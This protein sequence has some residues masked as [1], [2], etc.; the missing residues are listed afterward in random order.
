MSANASIKAAPT[1]TSNGQLNDLMLEIQ[2]LKTYFYTED[3]VVKAVDGVEV[4]LKPQ[5]GRAHV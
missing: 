3:G 1:S 5:I 4:R 2:G